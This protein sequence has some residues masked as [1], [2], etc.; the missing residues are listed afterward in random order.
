M[1]DEYFLDVETIIKEDE[2]DGPAR[3]VLVVRGFPHRDV[4]VD[5][6]DWIVSGIVGDEIKNGGTAIH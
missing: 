4:A 6:R 3:L 2:T 5:F 1:D